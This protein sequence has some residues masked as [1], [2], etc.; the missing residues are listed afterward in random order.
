MHN[1]T[2]NKK[3]NINSHNYAKKKRNSGGG[4]RQISMKTKYLP[5]TDLA[6]EYRQTSSAS[7]FV[8]S[9]INGFDAVRGTHHGGEVIS[10]GIGL[11]NARGKKEF[12]RAKD[13][14]VIAMRE[15]LGVHICSS[16]APVT[17]ICLGN[18]NFTADSLGALTAKKLIATRTPSSDTATPILK[19]IRPVS[20]LTPGSSAQSGMDACEL[21]LCCM[22][23]L[24]PST[25]ITVDA[26]KAADPDSL[27]ELVQLSS[28][29][30]TP[31]S[32]VRNSRREISR[33]TLGVPV[34]S[35]GVPTAISSDTFTAAAL[36]DAGIAPENRIFD[37]IMKKC[38]PLTVC[39]N[40]TDAAMPFFAALIG[41]AINQTLLGFSEL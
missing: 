25:V 23:T 11:S 12:M 29:G 34:L 3:L 35:I 37:K 19:N 6:I 7:S 14:L 36:S 40:D 31:G 39:K 26:L 30:V 2:V 10:I 1:K 22:D 33:R 15:L 21:L 18:G 16:I 32:G 38:E 13:A 5:K 17:V 28:L 9:K 20:V 27:C 41:K 24:R 4:K 8:K